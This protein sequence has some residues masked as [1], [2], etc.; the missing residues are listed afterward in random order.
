LVPLLIAAVSIL[1]TFLIVLGLTTF[2]DVSFVVQFLISLVGLGV[3]IDYSLLVVS[4][5]RG[6]RA[7]GR[8]NDE[9]IVTAAPTA[10]HAVLASGVTVAISLVALIVVPVPLLRSMGF[11]GMLIP[12][13]SVAVVLTL[14][15]ALLKLAPWVDYPRIRKE[16]RASRPWSA[17]AARGVPF[18]WVA[19]GVPLA[20]LALAIAP[21]FGIQ[22]GQASSASLAKNGEAHDS[23]VALADGGGGSGVLPPIPVLV[24]DGD[25]AAVAAAAETVEGV[26]AAVPWPAG[27]DGVTAV[28][29]IPVT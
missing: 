9:A 26:R 4:G 5:W 6:G 12:V 18:R 29:V 27:R 19:A 21:V 2:T 23:L 20:A 28:E 22:F 7:T 17:G 14:L 15:P 1:T 8:T 24:K 25:P 13:V 3:A 10:G 16:N 11:G